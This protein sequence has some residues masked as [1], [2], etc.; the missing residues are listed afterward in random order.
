M[1]KTNYE[2]NQKEQ[3]NKNIISLGTLKRSKVNELHRDVMINSSGTGAH[4]SK[5]TYQRKT[6][7]N[8]KIQY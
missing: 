1:K 3:K 5:K 2:V 8:D 7:H 6:K 4:K